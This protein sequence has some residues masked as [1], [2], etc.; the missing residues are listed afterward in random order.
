MKKYLL[1]SLLVVYVS[2]VAFAQ[3]EKRLNVYGSYV[4][5]DSFDSYYDAYNYYS[6]TIKG[7]G[8]Y[9]AGLEFLVKPEYGIELLWY[10]Q[11]TTAPTYYLSEGYF[12]TEEFTEFDV[13]A[14]YIMLAGNRHMLAPSG[15]VEGYGGLLLGVGF[16]S[17][18]NPD[19]GASG[20]FTKFS[21]GM[22]LGA[23]IWASDR[24]GIK[25]QTQI[26]SMVQAVGGSVYFGTGG[27]G[28]GVSTYS[29]FLQFGLGGG[30]AFRLGK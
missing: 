16:G 30:L 2:A 13:N 27:S 8:Q 26:L 22:R 28:A 10:G 20:N 6:G 24:I 12:Y 15:K 7:S 3:T 5:D 4:F 11:N 19:N 25:L 14:N 21:W 23:T 1:T 9:G 18:K 29:S 17:V